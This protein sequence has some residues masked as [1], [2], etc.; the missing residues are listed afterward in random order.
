MLLPSP[1]WLIIIFFFFKLSL[2]IFL[3]N[4]Q[5]LLRRDPEVDLLHQYHLVIHAQ[6]QQH[7]LVQMYPL[8][9]VTTH[10]MI[11]D[12]NPLHMHRMQDRAQ[13][14]L[15]IPLQCCQQES[16]LGELARIRVKSESPIKQLIICNM[17]F[18]M[19][20]YSQ[21]LVTYLNKIYVA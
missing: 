8:G 4:P 10:H 5:M 21:S 20:Y 1:R 3:G 11:W 15:P 12:G 7:H 17:N 14:H 18:L 9:V 6:V 16:V 2:V 19:K 13:V